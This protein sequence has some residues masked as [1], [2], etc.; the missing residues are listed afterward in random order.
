MQPPPRN[1]RNPLDLAFWGLIVAICVVMGGGIYAMGVRG[2]ANRQGTALNAQPSEANLAQ[3]SKEGPVHF[4]GTIEADP[5]SGPRRQSKTNSKGVSHPSSDLAG[6]EE[7][8]DAIASNLGELKQSVHRQTGSDAG[9]SLAPTVEFVREFRHLLETG[10]R[11]L[12]PV[13][14]DPEVRRS[15]H[16]AYRTANPISDE[17]P[18]ASDLNPPQAFLGEEEPAAVTAQA[19]PTPKITTSFAD[20]TPQITIESDDSSPTP[21]VDSD[22]PPATE[23][24][25]PDDGEEPMIEDLPSTTEV[26]AGS[27]LVPG[28][29]ADSTDTVEEDIIAETPSLPMEI[30]DPSPALTETDNTGNAIPDTTNPAP[31]SHQQD[32][33]ALE[34]D[35]PS[36]VARQL[37]PPAPQRSTPTNPPGSQHDDL[38]DDLAL[39]PAPNPKKE[40]PLTAIQLFYPKHRS[41]EQLVPEIQKYL[42]PGIGKVTATNNL[43]S[44]KTR[45]VGPAT[46]RRQAIA[47]KDTHAALQ[48][49]AEMLE[50]TDVATPLAPESSPA[51]EFTVD[52]TAVGVRIRPQRRSGIDLQELS[53]AAGA[54][55]LWAH[56]TDR[57]LKC[58][59]GLPNQR[60]G[61]LKLAVFNGE[62]ASLLRD[63]R[64]QGPLQAVARS[65]VTMKS[66]EASRLVVEQETG[67]GRRDRARDH[68]IGVRPKIH[69]DGTLRLEV[70]PGTDVQGRPIEQARETPEPIGE[71]ELRDGETAV[72]AGIFQ[73][74]PQPMKSQSATSRGRHD[75]E[76]EIVEW[77]YLLTPRKHFPLK[78]TARPP[79]GRP[80]SPIAQ[81]I[82][83]Q[84]QTASR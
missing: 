74:H 45:G 7:R 37:P 75:N 67:G 44:P 49:I 30:L 70:L 73:S 53:S 46:N 58:A 48:Q 21:E 3:S 56:P 55:T 43:V 10:Q 27:S 72:L 57:I 1:S 80:A 5:L 54:Y 12:H 4:D 39:P 25:V 18:A 28:E 41:V 42:T 79:Q 19:K 35:D 38:D 63:L 14:T 64:D 34:A 69:S 11:N 78:T 84:R 52:V 16:P 82:R 33:H 6:I 17:C 2:R 26:E 9:Q 81:R 62:E 77:I 76:G 29:Q 59:A 13:S 22:S 8:L 50:Q 66:T 65:R 32:L 60:D 31:Q 68:S 36:H 24:S 51:T 15:P 83:E 47:V 20:E 40:V 23:H 61:R 71:V